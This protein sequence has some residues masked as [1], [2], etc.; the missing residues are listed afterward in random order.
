MLKQLNCTPKAVNRVTIHFD[1]YG[2]QASQMH[3]GQ[4]DTRMGSP[5]GYT[6]MGH[7]IFVREIYAYGLEQNYLI[8]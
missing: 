2:V 7:P 5:C 6:H 4:A 8:T 1:P 3:M